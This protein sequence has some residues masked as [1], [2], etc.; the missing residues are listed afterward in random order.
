[1]Q[2]PLSTGWLRGIFTMNILGIVARSVPFG[3]IAVG[4]CLIGIGE[5][6]AQAEPSPAA[7]FGIDV[8]SS[9]NTATSLGTIDRCI[10]VEQGAS[11]DVDVFLDSIPSPH[12]LGGFEY[13]LRYDSTKLQVD[14]TDHGAGTSLIA[15]RPDSG[16]LDLGECSPQ[17]SP[18]P[19]TDGSL[20]ASVTDV[21]GQTSAEGPGELGVLG[22]YRLTVIAGAGS[23]TYLELTDFTFA[24][25]EP[26]VTNWT[27][28]IE[29]VWD[30]DWSPQY[31]IIAIDEPCPVF[32]PG[33]TPTGTPT[34]AVTAAVTSTQAPTPTPPGAATPT[35]PTPSAGG[36]TSGPWDMP[37]IAVYAVVG[38]AVVLLVGGL[39]LSRTR[40]R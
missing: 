19:Y 31:G 23:L 22:R 18:C 32:T 8:D 3:L 20:W 11:F 40:R 33:P 4:V 24:G 30:G 17:G 10:S 39:A 37:W 29:Q 38:A 12:N 5:T 16:G 6:F 27:S 2:E 21:S 7:I 1:M 9:G 26:G 15:S 28:E 25:Y 13:T 36:S 34:A 35:V 14:A